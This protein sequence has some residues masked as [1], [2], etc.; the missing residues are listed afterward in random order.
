MTHYAWL[1]SKYPKGTESRLSTIIE[2]SPD[3]PLLQM[4]ELPDQSAYIINHV[5]EVGTTMSSGLG[6]TPLSW[7]EIKSWSELT[8]TDLTSWE[9]S[10]I[11]ELSRT[12][13]SN[14]NKFDDKDFPTPYIIEEFD[15]SSASKN[16]GNALRFMAKRV[17]KK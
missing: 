13:T 15:R 9:A 17:N 10:L 16:I 14:Y 1:H 3:S 2:K 8:M 6:V 12:F 11:M 7:T 5:I 4:P